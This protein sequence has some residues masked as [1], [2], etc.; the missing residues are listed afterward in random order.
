MKI[1]KPAASPIS[2]H[3]YVLYTH[4]KYT[5]SRYNVQYNT[6]TRTVDNAFHNHIYEISLSQTT[7]REHMSYGYFKPLAWSVM[8]TNEMDIYSYILADLSCNIQG[9]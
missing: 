3:I 2:Y 6:Y 8:P 5:I 1:C 9:Q 7:T 4:K